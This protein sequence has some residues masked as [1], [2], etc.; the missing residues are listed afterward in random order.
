M[1]QPSLLLV[2]AAALIDG[3]GRVLICKRPKGKQLAGL[4]EFPGGK[5]DRE[6]AEWIDRL[7][8]EPG[9]LHAALGEPDLRPEESATL[10]VAAVREGRCVPVVGPALARA[11]RQPAQH[12]GVLDGAAGRAARMWRCILMDPDCNFII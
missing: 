11:P 10:F 7:D 12:G 2:A 6:D 1:S 8:T 9:P 5:V 4:W 3:D